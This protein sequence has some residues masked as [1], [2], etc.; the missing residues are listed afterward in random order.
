MTTSW[1]LLLQISRWSVSLVEGSG[2]DRRAKTCFFG[3]LQPI[4]IK[5]VGVQFAGTKNFEMIGIRVKE[6]ESIEL[7]AEDLELVEQ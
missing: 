6:S 4:T 2:D 3:A 7:P 1:L 5:S